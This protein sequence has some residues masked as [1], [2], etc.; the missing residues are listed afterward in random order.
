MSRE[1]RVVIIGAGMA[2]IATAHTLKQSGFTNFTILE[3]GSDVGGV[4]HWN[5]YPELTCDVPSQIYQFSFAPKPDWS[6]IWASGEEIQRYHRDVVGE[7]GLDAHLRLGTEVV[8]ARYDA[9]TTS[10]TLTAGDGETLTADFVICATGVLHHPFVPDIPGMDT[11][12]GRIVHTARWDPELVTA[13]RRI[14]VIGTGSTGVQ[15]VSALQPQA[16]TLIHFARSPQWILWAPMSLRQSSVVAKA[17]RRWPGWHDF[18]YRRLQWASGI[19]A[20][21]VT[22]PSWRRRLVQSYARWSLAAQVRNPALRAKLTPDYQPLCKRQVVSGTY[23][24]AINRPNTSLIA[25]PIREFTPAGIRTADGAHHEVDVVVLATGFQAHNYMRPMS[26]VGRDG[27]TLDD[28]WVKGPR[29]YR[30]TAIPGFPN[31]FTVLGPNS[32]TGSIPLQYSAE[33]TARYIV[34]WLKRFA[35]AELSEVEVT[36]EATD[37]FNAAVAGALGPTVWNTGCN[38]WYFTDAGTID[39]WP[40]DRATLTRMLSE[41]DPAHYRVR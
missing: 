23:Y 18:L 31:L 4:W 32:P 33:L 28:A 2:G 27:I 15:V 3:K 11:F 17:L 21:V 1:V 30:M 5:R 20:D 39:L 34:G 8:E 25:D 37:E 36:E 26:V 40:F 6:H 38:S 19:L 41:P 9:T 13:D 16:R 7:F 29:A 35:N 14:A 10:W 22:A 24:R 12:G